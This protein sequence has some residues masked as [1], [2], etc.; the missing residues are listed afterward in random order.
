MRTSESKSELSEM[1]KKEDTIVRNHLK[2]KI[3]KAILDSQKFQTIRF[4]RE[5]ILSDKITISEAN[6]K[7]SIPLKKN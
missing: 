6:Q 3:N 1:K 5:S 7:Q 4:F 2:Y